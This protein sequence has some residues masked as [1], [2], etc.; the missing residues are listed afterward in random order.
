MRIYLCNLLILLPLIATNN[1]S[2]KE[3]QK[4]AQQKVWTDDY[5]YGELEKLP[6]DLDSKNKK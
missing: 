3:P 2:A 5:Q 1:A 4:D 6:S